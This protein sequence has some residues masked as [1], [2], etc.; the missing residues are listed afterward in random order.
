MWVAHAPFYD[1]TRHYATCPEVKTEE[2]KV[3]LL[4][5]TD[6]MPMCCYS[7]CKENESLIKKKTTKTTMSIFNQVSFFPPMSQLILVICYKATYLKHPHTFLE[8]GA[9]THTHN[10]KNGH[11]CAHTHPPRG[12][13]T[14]HTHTTR[15]TDTGVRAHTHT[16]KWTLGTAPLWCLCTVFI[17]S[18]SLFTN[19]FKVP[20]AAACVTP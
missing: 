17:M 11:W 9:R 14:G 8:V 16:Q 5:I 15:G 4:F 12:M 18:I 1:I 13:D 10:Q 20:I 2:I 6:E 7:S 3:C 19:L